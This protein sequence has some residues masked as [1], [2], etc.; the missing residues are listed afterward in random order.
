MTLR[1]CFEHYHLRQQNRTLLE[2]VQR[3]NESLQRLN[4]QLKELMNQRTHSL[5]L[6]Q[7]ILA[8]LPIGVVGLGADGAVVMVNEAVQTLFPS[9]AGV[10][11]GC[12]LE[13]SAPDW[14]AAF[15][16]ECMVSGK[17]HD[18]KEGNLDGRQVR[19]Q[20]TLFKE[21]DFLAGSL[22]IICPHA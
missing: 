11:L 14:I 8:K 18:S 19:M 2:Q 15:M 5:R 1:Q 20:A 16:K 17:D 6:T 21:G 7:D 3:Q 9:M 10:M 13:E 12:A 4:L 22:L